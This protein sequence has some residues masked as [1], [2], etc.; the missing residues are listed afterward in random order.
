MKKLQVPVG[1]SA[2]ASMM[3]GMDAFDAASDLI[4]TLSKSRKM[5]CITLLSL[6]ARSETGWKPLLFGFPPGFINR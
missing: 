1:H 5:V 4:P 3:P 6:T 2:C